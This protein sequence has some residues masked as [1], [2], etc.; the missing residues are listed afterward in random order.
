M[1]VVGT[2]FAGADWASGSMSNQLLFEPR[3]SKVWLAKTGALFAGTVAVAAVLTAAFWV[4]LYLVAESRGIPTGATVQESIRWMA[5]RGALLAGVGAVAG[6]ALTMLLRHT[7]GT[8]GLLFAYVA[9]GEAIIALLPV[10]GIGRWSLGY[11]VMGWLHDGYSYWDQSLPCKGGGF[12]CDRT[13]LLTLGEAVVYLGPLLLLV[14][15]VSMLSFR[16]RDIP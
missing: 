1:V 8:L 2:T 14:M 3:R 15:L 9:A 7:V 10:E 13:A 4:T 6:Y 11:N 5:G 12:D 16:R